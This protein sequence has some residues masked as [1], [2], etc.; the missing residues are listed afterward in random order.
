[1]NPLFLFGYTE[2]ICCFVER[3]PNQYRFPIRAMSKY[4]YPFL[5][6]AGLW[7]F[8]AFS[9]YAQPDKVN[10]S[11]CEPTQNKAAE[12][13]FARAMK[14]SE[15]GMKRKGLREALELEPAYYEAAYQLGRRAYFVKRNDEALVQFEMVT[16]ACP[17]YAPYAWY[18]MGKIYQS[19]N[20]APQALKAFERFLSFEAGVRDQEYEELKEL[21][22]ALKEEAAL[23]AVEVDFQPKPLLDVST[24]MD[25]YSASITPDNRYIYF[26]RKTL[27]ERNAMTAPGGASGGADLVEVFYRSELKDGKWTS[28]TPL[29]RPFN[30]G[31]NNGAAAVTADNKFMYFVVCENNQAEQCDLWFTQWEHYRWKAL[32]RLSNVLN[33]P[34]YWDS[35][36][37]ISYDGNTL[38]FASDRP[39]GQG[40][41]DLYLSTKQ[42]DGSWSRPQNLGPEINTAGNEI[43]PFLHSDSQTLYFSSQGHQNV[44]G[45]DVFFSKRKPDGTWSKPQNLGFPLNTRG[46]E[47]SFFVSLD[48]QTA[49]MCSDQLQD[50]QGNTI[51]VGGLDVFTFPLHLKARPEEVVLM[52]GQLRTPEGQ[53]LGGTISIRDE[54]TQQITTIQA[55]STDGKFVAMVTVGKQFTFTVNQEGLAFSQTT[56][57]TRGHRAGQT[58]ALEMESGPVVSGKSY[59]LSNINFATNAS[60]LPA[61]SR[62]MLADF[63]DWLK[64]NASVQIRVEG[65]TDNVGQAAANLALS[66]ARAQSVHDFLVS[67]G[68]APERLA[69]EGYGSSR[70]IASNNNEEGRAKNRRTEFFIR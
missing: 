59:R 14:E 24:K 56:V 70:P 15:E 11:A 68:I 26:T 57:D 49:F 51:Q 50:K 16:Q 17:Q 64:T 5:T 36:P 25:E 27:V 20:K 66:K 23:M 22:P 34:G 4:V 1:M 63:A 48:G 32:Q 2:T 58:Q 55:D 37:T 13:A 18:Y 44:G 7:W 42:P 19:L 41:A 31:N 53:N 54:Q 10:A 52:E 9:L 35:H 38:I 60:D 33:Y 62:Q 43:T 8:S 3:G 28:G 12:K 29:E 65:H 40:K 69:F 39:G 45:F 21:L 61:E 30:L 47:V 67:Q 6:V 46:D